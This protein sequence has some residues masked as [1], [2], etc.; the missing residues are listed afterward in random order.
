MKQRMSI[1]TIFLLIISGSLCLAQTEQSAAKEDFKPASTNQPGREYPQVNSER[2][3]RV[4]FLLR[5]QPESSLI[6]MQ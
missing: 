4:R 1:L 6:S 2:R 5:K 3:V